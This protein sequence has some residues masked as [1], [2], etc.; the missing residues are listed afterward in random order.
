MV[1]YVI[2]LSH[3]SGITSCECWYMITFSG[4]VLI[5]VVMAHDG[6]GPQSTLV[7]CI[8]KA[9]GLFSPV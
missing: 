7:E 1:F 9:L 5:L 6:L 3:S 8:L 2:I 4:K